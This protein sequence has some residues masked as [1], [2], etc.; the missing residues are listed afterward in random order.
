MLPL[1]K[2]DVRGKSKTNYSRMA[3]QQKGGNNR[4]ETG[5]SFMSIN[6]RSIWKLHLR[7][8]GHVKE[9][10]AT[11]WLRSKESAIPGTVRE[12]ENKKRE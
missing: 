3:N 10:D 6:K 8:K 9:V 5:M 11:R 12:I 4:E 7:H 1:Y 2:G